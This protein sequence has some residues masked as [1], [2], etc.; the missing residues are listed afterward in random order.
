MTE[1]ERYFF[2]VRGYH[3][4]E[5]ALSP[6]ELKTLNALFDA[7]QAQLAN[8]RAGRAR[9]LELMT[10]GKAYR[11]LI[12]HPGVLPHLEEMLGKD[13]RLDHEYAE[14]M[15][16]GGAGELHIN[17]TPYS[18]MFHYH[19]ANNQIHC[20]L[21]AVVWALQDV[22]PGAGGFCCI[23]GSHKSSFAPPSS[24]TCV[25]QPTPGVQQIP[26]RAGSA[27]IFTEALR[28]GTLAWTAPTQR[29]S[30]FYKYSPRHISWWGTY[31]DPAAYDYTER[32]RQL[33]RSPYQS[34]VWNDPPAKGYVVSP[35]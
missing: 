9:Y 11:D 12:D 2:D 24:I 8:P 32:Q 29:R 26:C 17:G 6:E 31:Y 1:E 10:W 30:L 16:E 5:D 28:H 20:G 21:V 22:P 3:L 19:V 13:L 15:I 7:Q 35:A 14:H 34:R 25:G 27:I 18:T 4:V 33:L 23:P